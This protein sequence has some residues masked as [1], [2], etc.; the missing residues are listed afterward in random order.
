M[1]LLDNSNTALTG[2][3]VTEKEKYFYP[4]PILF[5]QLNDLHVV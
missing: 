2:K 3:K 4:H 1:D 5:S